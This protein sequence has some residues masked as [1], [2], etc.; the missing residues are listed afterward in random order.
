MTKAFN[1]LAPDAETDI[2]NP[3]AHD[4][5]LKDLD[6]GE[7]TDPEDEDEELDRE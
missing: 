6:T 2:D 3:V 1:P 5:P 7:I 4:I